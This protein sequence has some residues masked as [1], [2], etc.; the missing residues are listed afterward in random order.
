MTTPINFDLCRVGDTW[1]VTSRDTLGA[2]LGAGT[3]IHE[4]L[5]AFRGL[6]PLD[7]GR[8]DEAFD[9]CIERKIPT[10]TLVVYDPAAHQGAEMNP[11]KSHYD[12]DLTKYTLDG[13]NRL[14]AA[15]RAPW[16]RDD[17][18]DAPS[19]TWLRE[20]AQEWMRARSGEQYPYAEV[21]AFLD[22]PINYEGH[23]VCSMWA[24]AF[25]FYL[26]N[27]ADAYCNWPYG[28]VRD[29]SYSAFHPGLIS[30]YELHHGLMG[31][32]WGVEIR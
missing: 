26:Q 17:R 15:F 14:L 2:L 12:A 32:G 24:L 11:P 4:A 6:D 9:L 7:F 19:T 23:E 21:L 1:S 30:P 22:L 20:R 8:L 10:H 25:Q 31:L 18:D 13:E 5:E 3:V 27:S 28:W 29:V 16:M